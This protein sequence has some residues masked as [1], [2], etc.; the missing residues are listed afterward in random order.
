MKK[1]MSSADSIIRILIAALIT[2][3]FFT[4]IITGTF[5]IVMIIVAAIFLATSVIGF[6]P[7]YA[8]IGVKTCKTKSN[9]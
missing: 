9:L 6:C 3:L 8:L 4:K 7:L 1:N 2:V 5:A